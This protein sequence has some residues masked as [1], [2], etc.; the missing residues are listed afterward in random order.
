MDF[1]GVKTQAD[2]RQN[3]SDESCVKVNFD[4]RECFS[5]GI[6]EAEQ[7]EV[8]FSEM[9]A[10]RSSDV[11]KEFRASRE[12]TEKKDELSR[13][14][15]G[16]VASLHEDKLAHLDKCTEEYKEQ[17][18]AGQTVS[19][20]DMKNVQQLWDDALKEYD[21]SSAVLEEKQKELT[22]NGPAEK[23]SSLL[24]KFGSAAGIAAILTSPVPE[25]TESIAA[26]FGKYMFYENKAGVERAMEEGQCR[27]AVDD[28]VVCDSGPESSA[29]AEDFGSIQAS[30]S[31]DSDYSL[32]EQ[33]GVCN[34]N[35][36]VTYKQKY[37]VINSPEENI[38]TDNDKKLKY[39]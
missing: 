28:T 26:L 5:D 24:S 9:L 4:G 30:F 15:F 38:F 12:F 33:M 35:M 20:D 27:S 25:N 16:E 34:Q 1:D 23:E 19:P 13:L 32:A 3:T 21:V 31:L 37:E 7:R 14:C 17:Y 18:L 39:T 36:T 6:F 10:S 2:Q 8:L 22:V 29:P 11:V